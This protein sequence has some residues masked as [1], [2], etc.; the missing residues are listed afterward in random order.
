MRDFSDG[1]LIVSTQ[2]RMGTPIPAFM[3]RVAWIDFILPNMFISKYTMWIEFCSCTFVCLKNYD[4]ELKSD[5]FME[6][7]LYALVTLDLPYIFDIFKMRHSPGIFQSNQNMPP[8]VNKIPEVYGATIIVPI[9]TSPITI[10]T[11]SIIV[12]G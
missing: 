5:Y 11:L 1:G 7:I 6:I 10:N 2:I 9:Y 4:L 3:R 12:K 8:S